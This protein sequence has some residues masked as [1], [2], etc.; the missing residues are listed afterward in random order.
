MS[1]RSVVT[2][3][4]VVALGFLALVPGEQLLPLR[5]LK[6][7][8]ALHKRWVGAVP[9]LLWGVFL[10]CGRSSVLVTHPLNLLR[11]VRI[12]TSDEALEYVRFFSNADSYDLFQLRSMVEVF[13]WRG[14]GDKRFNELDEPAFA[15]HFQRATAKALESTAPPRTTREDG[16]CRGRQF[17]IKRVVLLPDQSI[18]QMVEIVF[19]DGYYS[20][21]SQDILIKDASSIGLQYF[22]PL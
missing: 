3:Q 5:S 15:S 4:S 11:Q 21:A 16:C 20:V 13:P 2:V 9:A 18:R 6:P 22:W 17:E 19:E 8:C 14:L 7:G 10:E 12:R 1:K